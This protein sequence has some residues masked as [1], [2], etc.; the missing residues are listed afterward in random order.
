MPKILGGLCDVQS[1]FL[2]CKVVYRFEAKKGKFFIF[3]EFYPRHLVVQ[4]CTMYVMDM[5]F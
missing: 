5:V 1:D 2:M 4:L 3:G